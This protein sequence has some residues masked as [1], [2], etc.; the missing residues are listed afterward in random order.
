MA[1]IT[2]YSTLKDNVADWLNR[3][4]LTAQIP[5]FIQ[6]AEAELNRR[7]RVKDSVTRSDA[8]V[9]TQYTT[10]PS[11]F[12]ETKSVYLKT[13]PVSR[14]EY[15]TI[16]QMEALKTQGYSATGQ[17]RYYTV[18]GGT[19]ETLPAPDQSY[20]AEL[21]YYAKLAALSDTNTTNWLLTKNPDIYLFGSLLQSAPYLRDD[22]RIPVWNS[23]YERGLAQ[24]E[25]AS[26]RA[27]FSG[28][29]LKARVRSY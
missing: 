14:L 5:V 27:E 10:L 11:D 12:A 4:D 13:S 17:P 8:T 9:D 24:L 16:E 20:T 29:V 23:V 25:Q 26:D 19:F 7:L 15:I 18:I 28:G 1:Q 21:V 22:D 2:S 3:T 6:L